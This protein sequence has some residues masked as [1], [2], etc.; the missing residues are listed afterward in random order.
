MGHKKPSFIEKIAE[1]LKIIP[2]LHGD[3][4][5]PADRLTEEGQLTDF[6]P[7]EQWNDWVEYEAKSWPLREK[8]HYSIV[9]TTCFNC[10]SACGLTA[11]IDKDTNKIR[12]LEGNPYHPGSRGRNCAKGPATINQLTDPDRIL[13]PLKRSRKTWRWR[14]GTYILG[15][16]FG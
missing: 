1:K 13:Y 11:F 14:V 2:D 6:P 12:K 10:E 4:G 9:P 5:A 8:K 16:G 15:S 3:W 7:P